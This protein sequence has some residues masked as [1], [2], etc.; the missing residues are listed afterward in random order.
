MPNNK[1]LSRLRCSTPVSD[2]RSEVEVSESESVENK[3]KAS[4]SSK[5][6]VRT[7][8][9]R[10]I[11]KEHTKQN[12]P[13]KMTKFKSCHTQ[14]LKDQ[15]PIHPAL[16]DD[17]IRDIPPKTAF[18]T[19]THT[20]TLVKQISRSP[21]KSPLKKSVHN[22]LNNDAI[23]VEP[24]ESG[25]NVNDFAEECVNLINNKLTNHKYVK[26]KDINENHLNKK[27]DMF[28]ILLDV[29]PSMVSF[30]CL[31]LFLLS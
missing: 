29:R 27:I 16:D 2:G 19:N 17:V 11:L 18:G 30:N 25:I 9:K 8:L 28:V 14:K 12:S 1:L 10:N 20:K 31:T 21:K 26:I 7:V 3:Q 5:G 24:E 13:K 15:Q 22:K 6:L 23:T 4:C